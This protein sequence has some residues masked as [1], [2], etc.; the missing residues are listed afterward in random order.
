MIYHH[1]LQHTNY[2]V[3]D[4]FRYANAYIQRKPLK[5]LI[6]E[7]QSN[8]KLRRYATRKRER[9]REIEKR[10]RNVDNRLNTIGNK[11]I[12]HYMFTLL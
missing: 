1:S 7:Q 11:C 8:L 6:S 10:E 4:L 9:E 2:Y 12:L 3:E 5:R